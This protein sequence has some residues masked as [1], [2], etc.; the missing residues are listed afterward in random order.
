MNNCYHTTKTQFL[1]FIK[2]NGLQPIYGNN[3]YLTADPRK[4]KVSYSVG[5]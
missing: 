5:M 4:N 1:S 2:K 3:S